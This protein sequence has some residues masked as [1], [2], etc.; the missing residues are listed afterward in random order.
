M[1]S[2]SLGADINAPDA[3]GYTPLMN[4]AMLGRLKVVRALIELGADV[5][6]KGQFGYTAL[7]AAAQG[8]H[9]EAVQA[10][11]KY[12]AS[13]NCKNDDGDI[14]LILGMYQKEEKDKI[15]MVYS[16]FKLFV[17]LMQKLLIIC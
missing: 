13:V 10:L 14:P 4:A 16:L 2:L 11:V 5:Q 17:E 15:P 12:G 7:H 6:R 9:L 3:Y 8:G 1:F